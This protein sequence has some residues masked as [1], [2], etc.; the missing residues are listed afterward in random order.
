MNKSTEFGKVIFL[1]G[2]TSSGKSTIASLLQATISEPFW[3][4]SIDTLRDGGMLPLDRIN[5]GEF[6]WSELR[7]GFF[8]GFHHTLPAFVNAGNNLIVE[9]I[10][11]T[12]EWLGIL[13]SLLAP[14]DVYFVGIH[15]PLEVLEQRELARR[16]R[17]IGGARK[18]FETI[19]LHTIYDLELNA[20]LLP[21]QNVS[22]LIQGWTQRTRPSAFNL[23][24]SQQI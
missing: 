9:H 18:D 1:N 16:N 5:S 17:P 14:F 19:H 3:H 10:V 13:L 12:K 23:M 15:A 7:A 6:K 2:A 21:E 22:I 4:V 20:T 8:D 11:E 24:Y